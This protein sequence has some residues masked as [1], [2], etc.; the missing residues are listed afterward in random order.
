[1]LCDRPGWRDTKLKDITHGDVQRWISGLSVNGSVRTEG[2]G[3]SPSR[4]IQTQQCLPAVLKY[5]MRTDR[6]LKN[7]ANGI[8]LPRRTVGEHRYLTHQQLR[9]LADG[10]SRG[11]DRPDL[12]VLTAVMG[13]SRVA[14]RGGPRRRSV[15]PA[16]SARPTAYLRLAG[17]RCGRQR[18]GHTAA[19]RPTATMTLDTYGHLFSDDLTR[20]AAA[21]DKVAREAGAEVNG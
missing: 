9:K 5:A 19:T 7:V 10:V 17:H 20:V 12:L 2:N 14:V 15:F 11:D 6:L 4:V 21:L 3:L 16:W 1:V 13:V 8:E 18:S